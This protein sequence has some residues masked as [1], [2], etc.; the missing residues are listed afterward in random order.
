MT[1]PAIPVNATYSGD[2]IG[3]LPPTPGGTDGDHG[4]RT[5]NSRVP[6]PGGDRGHDCAPVKEAAGHGDELIVFH[7]SFIPRR[8]GLGL[9][10]PGV[11]RH[12]IREAL[13]HKRIQ[14]PVVPIGEAF[15]RQCANGRAVGF[16][17]RNQPRRP[18]GRQVGVND[19][20]VGRR[21]A[22]E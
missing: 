8:S 4:R 3:K 1:R 18:S 10:H 22:G 7:E 5:R 17:Y 20:A 11:A 6:R 13:L 9:A 12:R 14:R 2:E 19:A 16:G 15:T 21:P